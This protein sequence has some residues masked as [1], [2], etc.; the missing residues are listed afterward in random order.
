MAISPMAKIMIVCH[1]TEASEL[2]EALQRAEIVEILDAE[3]TMVTKEWPE[4]LV[5]I[6]RPKDLEDMLA[7]LRKGIAFLE[8]YNEVKKGVL[9]PKAVVEERHYSEVVKGSEAV[10]LLDKV[11]NCSARLE[12]LE[13]E[14]DAARGQLGM[15]RPW[16]ELKTPLEE[17]TGFDKAACIVGLI[18][19]RFLGEAR[20]RVEE[21]GAVVEVVG[22]ADRQWACVVVC[23]K[24]TATE[25]QRGLR[26]AEFE[27]VNFGGMRGTAPELIEQW[28]EKL[29][30]TEKQLAEQ[31]RRAAELANEQLKLKILF[32]HYN[33]LT[34]RE[35]TRASAPATEKTV[36]LEGW[37]KEQDYARL[38]EVVGRFSTTGISRI[39]PGEGERPPVEIENKPLIRP[40]E[41][42]T[43]LY[44]MPEN[45]RVDPTAFLAPFFALFFGICMTDAGYGLVM[46]A[47]FWWIAKKFQGDKKAFRML[48][49]CSVLAIVAGA[50][51]GGWFG[52]TIQTLVPAESGVGKAL[53]AARDKIMLFDPMQQP[54]IFF[55][56]SLTLGYIQVLF[57][58]FVA[59]F[60][61]IS[62]KDYVAAV[63][64]QL[65]WLIFLNSLLLFAL[66]KM[67]YLP[68]SLS[69]VLIVVALIQAAVIL[70]FSER[71]GGWGGRIGMG[72]FQLFST[73]FYFGDVLS[74]VRL[75][76]LGMVTGGFGMAVNVIV[77]LL[78][79]LGWVGWIFGAIVFVLLHFVNIALSTLSA[80][81]HTLRLQYVEFFPK[82]F[83][84]GG[85]EFKLLRKENRY[86]IVKD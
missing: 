8:E 33:N 25:V 39:D 7:R 70:L 13:S 86:V 44:G 2:L 22:Q 3:R 23:L 9:A 74:Y 24:E 49:I 31:R 61:N 56:I 60:H 53:N 42:V 59:F 40:F 21:L 78:L 43:R 67:G 81:V 46:A 29:A 50:L 45:F 51:T 80:F 82:F 20:Q 4:L 12:Q 64:D 30:E 85:K 84:G 69:T 66:S 65:T 72:A 26:A 76:A 14:R 68:G 73:V 36:L 79:D 55:G 57:G 71:Q 1:R 77:K 10:E 38:E 58:L 35:H 27:A 11:E 16:K 47:I 83:T 18:P 32:D 52:D 28:E 63:C 34:S 54:M 62:R 6:K 48:I 15:L 75:M 5:D 17:L 19:E 37:V 41:V